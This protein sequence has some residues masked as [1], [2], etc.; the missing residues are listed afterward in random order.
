MHGDREIG[1]TPGERAIDH[2]G[3][4]AGLLGR[5]VAAIGEHLALRR[6]AEIG[7]AAIVELQIAAAGIVEAFDRL[8]IGETE[9]VI[10]ILHPRIERLIDHL[11]A[12]AIVQHRGARDGHFRRSSSYALSG[13]RNA[14]SSG[15]AESRACR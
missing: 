2:A 8:T 4:D 5:I 15:D 9:I 6:I 14:R 11:A 7:E 12:A 10:E 3:I 1:G 13:T